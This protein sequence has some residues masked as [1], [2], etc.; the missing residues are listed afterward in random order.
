[1][2]HAAA[3]IA[4]V[5]MA[6]HRDQPDLVLIVAGWCFATGVFLFSFGLF[7]LAL[8]GIALFGRITP[9]GGASFAA[10]LGS[11]RARCGTPTMTYAR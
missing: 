11:A 8:T 5:A 7:A 10:W 9:F 2:V 4:V 1:M 6:G 3:L